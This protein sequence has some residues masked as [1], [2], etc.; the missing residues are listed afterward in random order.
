V[1][2]GVRFRRFCVVMSGLRMVRMGQVS[3]MTSLFVIAIF[4]ML[5]GFAVMF[6]GLV[7]VRRCVRMVF[8]CLFRVFHCAL[9]G[10]HRA[11]RRCAMT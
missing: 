7:M 4:M 1:V 2:I 8:G 11:S 3:V 5:S 6:S 9:L 10:C